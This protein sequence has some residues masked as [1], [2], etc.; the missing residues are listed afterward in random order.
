M[1]D[2][3]RRGDAQIAN[4]VGADFT[5]ATLVPEIG[6]GL[7]RRAFLRV[8]APVH[9]KTFE[10]TS[11]RIQVETS[12]LGDIELLGGWEPQPSKR[13][14]A[15]LALG[16]ALPTGEHVAQPFVGQAAPTALQ[17][18][19][20][21][22]DPLASAAAEYRASPQWSADARAAARVALMANMHDYRPASIYELST[23]GRW[24]ALPRRLGIGLHATYS[25]VTKVQVD[26]TAAPNTGRDTIY[27]EPSLM[28][29]IR[30]GLGIEASARIPLYMR[31]NE[32]QLAETALLAVRLMYQTPPLF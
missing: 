17:L 23:G 31:V 5:V 32:T 12:G 27:L 24:R 18:G 4:D 16:L 15:N 7:P 22:M 6:Y 20:G 28:A 8:R 25:H 29:T 26:G 30:P 11:P 19:S 21:T 1:R 2:R 10:E 3:L 13:W 9:W 14:R